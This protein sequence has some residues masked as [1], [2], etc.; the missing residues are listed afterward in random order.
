VALGDCI[1]NAICFIA[2]VRNSH[3]S[4]A[5]SCSQLA[6][7]SGVQ[8]MAGSG[9]FQVIYSSILMVVALLSR[10]ILGKPISRG[11]ALWMGVVSAGLL[12]AG[13]APLLATSSSAASSSP[14][15]AALLWCVAGVLAYGLQYIVYECA[16]ALPTLRISPKQ[17]CVQVGLYG[18]IITL[19][20]IC[21]YTVRLRLVPPLP[22]RRLV[23]CI[24]AGLKTW[25]WGVVRCQT[26]AKCLWSPWTRRR[27]R[28]VAV[29]T[30]LQC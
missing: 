24:F 23:L 28:P 3:T 1:A 29:W 7:V 30:P 12:I 25:V 27:V 19:S 9:L 14:S 2:M 13:V 16:L 20:Y 17:L 8:V 10:V 21:L 11:A 22:L 6:Y 4:A 5:V 15:P 18:S 26:T